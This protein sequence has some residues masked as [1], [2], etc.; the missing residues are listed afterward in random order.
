LQFCRETTSPPA[1]AKPALSGQINARIAS[2]NVLDYS[3]LPQH[4]AFR[5]WIQAANFQPNS[6]LGSSDR[7]D[8]MIA[9]SEQ[10]NNATSNK[11]QEQL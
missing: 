7:E 3:F 5:G 4:N 1:K 11:P 10:L 9:L 2:K 6:E 8:V